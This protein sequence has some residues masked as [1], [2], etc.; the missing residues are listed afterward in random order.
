MRTLMLLTCIWIG[1]P[2]FAQQ[3]GKSILFFGYD[4]PQLEQPTLEKMEKG[5]KMAADSGTVYR[6]ELVGLLN[7]NRSKAENN[8]LLQ[9]RLSELKSF[10]KKKGMDE[11]DFTV[12]E[13]EVNPLLM[14]D[15]QAREGLVNFEVEVRIRKP[16][17]PKKKPVFKTLAAVDPVETQVE[18]IN[19]KKYTTIH[20]KEGTV[21][22]IKKNAFMFA[23][24]SVANAPVEVQLREFYDVSSWLNEGLVTTCNGQLIESGG[25]VHISAKCEGKPVELRPGKA[26]E[27]AMPLDGAPRK[28][29]MQTFIGKPQNG[30]INWTVPQQITGVATDEISEQIRNVEYIPNNLNDN[31][32][33][34]WNNLNVNQRSWSP[35][36]RK[37]VKEVDGYLIESSQLGWINCDRFTDEKEK[38]NMIVK[39]DT[40]MQPVVRVV[41]S[42]INSMMPGNF[43]GTDFAVNNIPVGR[44]VTVIAYTIKDEQPYLAMR[45]VKISDN[46]NLNLDM[47]PVSKEELKQSFKKMN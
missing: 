27:L 14:R 1:L 39:A 4:A 19:P 33:A 15:G 46:L 44:K 26:I 3:P 6:F 45:E 38:T 12:S 22:H 18:E 8:T 7:R 16:K 17:K 43:N 10:Y 31:R 34:N 47:K 29:G 42:D 24:G 13:V 36:L 41:F 21:I 11:Q 28:E 32:N 40:A 9:Q 30:I 20:G 2:T 25:M 37:E 23:D 35:N 5:Y